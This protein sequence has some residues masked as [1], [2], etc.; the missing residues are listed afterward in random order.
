[1]GQ[2]L[3]GLDNKILDVLHGQPDNTS[4]SRSLGGIHVV[5]VS[6]IGI[7]E[8]SQ[9]PPTENGLLSLCSPPTN[10]TIA[11]IVELVGMPV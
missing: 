4:R 1:M 9:L 6:C 3:M 7:V 10:A 5:T 11:V 2:H 8:G